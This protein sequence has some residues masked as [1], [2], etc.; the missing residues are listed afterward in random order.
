MID[1]AFAALATYDWGDDVQKLSAIEQAV[2]TTRDDPAARQELEDRLIAVLQAD[3]SRDAR[4]YVCRKLRVVGTAAAVPALAEL[5]SQEENSHMA[6][7]ALERIPD[8]QAAQALREALSALSGKLKIGVIASLGARPDPDSV[9]LLA[10]L[11]DDSDTAVASAAAQALGAIRTPEAAA[12]LMKMTS[13]AA[14]VQLAVTDATLACA[15]AQL[16]AG[17]KAR[18]LAL[19]KSLAGG[20]HPKHIRLAATRGMLACAGKSE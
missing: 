2:V 4:D 18:A 8:E 14:E 11:L 13:A 17:Q 7:Y 19:Y 9:K 1:K 16:A 3:V 5:L 6:R 12:E 15:E 20:D 10:G